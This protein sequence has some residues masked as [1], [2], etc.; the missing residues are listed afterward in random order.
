MDYIPRIRHKLTRSLEEVARKYDGSSVREAVIH[1]SSQG[2]SGVTA[3]GDS[4]GIIVVMLA[5]ALSR[6]STN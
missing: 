6:V 4:N 2:L 5:T 1:A 3:F